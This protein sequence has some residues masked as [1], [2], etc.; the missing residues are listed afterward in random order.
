MV[1]G[2]ARVFDVNRP[3]DGMAGRGLTYLCRNMLLGGGGVPI[4]SFLIEV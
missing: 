2:K 3:Y 1:E 4:V